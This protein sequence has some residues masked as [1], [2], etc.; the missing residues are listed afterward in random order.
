VIRIGV[1]AALLR[2]SSTDCRA[3]FWQLSEKKQPLAHQNPF[4]GALQ[5]IVSTEA[6]NKEIK[7]YCQSLFN[8]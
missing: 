8:R 1:I 3:I 5:K 4:W 7:P 6:V 2:Q